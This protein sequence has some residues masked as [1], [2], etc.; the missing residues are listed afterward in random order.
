MEGKKRK[1][2]GQQGFLTWDTP[3]GSDHPSRRTYGRWRNMVEEKGSNEGE[4][5]KLETA[6]DTVRRG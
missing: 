3:L 4:I 1:G 6:D 5:G 2:T